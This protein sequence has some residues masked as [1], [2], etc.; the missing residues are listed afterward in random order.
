MHRHLVDLL[1]HRLVRTTS[2]LAVGF[3]LSLAVNNSPA[4]TPVLGH[5]TAQPKATTSFTACEQEALDYAF[6]EDQY[7]AALDALYDAYDALQACG[8]GQYVPSEEQEIKLASMK[9]VLESR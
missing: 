1:N 8:Y 4:T 6:A 2:L 5:V 9:S 7:D 3:V